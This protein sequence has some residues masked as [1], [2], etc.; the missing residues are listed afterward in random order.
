MSKDLCCCGA[1][2][3]LIENLIEEEV[4]CGCGILEKIDISKIKNPKNSKT[5][6]KSFLLKLF[7]KTSVELGIVGIGYIKIP[8]NVLN[9]N[10]ILKYSNA[11]VLTFPIGMNV[12][13]EIPSEYAQKLN[14][15]LYE[16]FGKITYVLSD[17]LRKEGFAT[18]VINPFGGLIDLFKLGQEAGLGYIGKN[19]LL[20]SPELGPRLKVSAIL[21]TI[22]N[23]PFSEEN[24]HEWIK[25]Y[26][27][28]CGKCIKGCPEGALI[29]KEDNLAKASLIDEKCIGC[30]Q[31]CTYCI[32]SC[33]FF[34][35]GYNW[36]KEKQIKLEAKLKEK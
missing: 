34:E 29:E 25:N 30:S 1:R 9:S 11:I 3:E 17:Y 33:P 27:K 19:G 5:K 23:L 36:V 18:Q 2:E 28:R 7:E 24:S 13:N 35:N 20:I 31:G 22:E 21:T 14:N 6:I 16:I 8:V 4:G 12:I 15:E 26:C 10:N 32:E